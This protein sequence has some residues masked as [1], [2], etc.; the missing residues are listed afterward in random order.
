MPPSCISAHSQALP[1]HSIG[2]LHRL[3]WVSLAAGL[4]AV[5]EAPVG[6]GIWAKFCPAA[7]FTCM[8]NVLE[9][10]RL[11]GGRMANQRPHGACCGAVGADSGA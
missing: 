11:S 6:T 8:K 3:Q 1:G 7:L 5:G 4:G 9:R 2:T 10:M